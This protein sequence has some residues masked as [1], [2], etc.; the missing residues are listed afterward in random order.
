MGH[1]PNQIQTPIDC[2][3]KWETKKKCMYVVI[4]SYVTE[5]NSANNMLLSQ[6]VTLSILSFILSLSP[7]QYCLFHIDSNTTLQIQSLSLTTDER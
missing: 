7:F 1:L 2:D 3:R 5:K 6:K 4:V